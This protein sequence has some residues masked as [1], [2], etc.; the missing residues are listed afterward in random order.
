MIIVKAGQEAT[1]RRARAS[2]EAHLKHKEESNRYRSNTK[3]SCQVVREDDESAERSGTEV[4]LTHLLKRRAYSLGHDHVTLD[5][6]I[7]AQIW[8]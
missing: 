3:R 6:K 1:L 8:R 7:S 2:E 4:D 5:A